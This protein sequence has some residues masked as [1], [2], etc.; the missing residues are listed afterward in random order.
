M[1]KFY[2]FTL[3]LLLAFPAGIQAQEF[4][5]GALHVVLGTYGRV[6]VS[7]PDVSVR[8]V[9]R[10]SFLLAKSRTEVFDYQEDAE[11]IVAPATV[12]PATWGDFEINVGID[13]S[14]S[15][16]PP[17]VSAVVSNYGW[18]NASFTISKFSVTNNGTEAFNAIPGFEM[19]PIN[20]GTYG[21]EVLKYDADNSLFY[22]YKGASYVGFKSLSHPLTSVTLFDW[23]DLFYTD[24][25]FYDYMTTGTFSDSVATG[26]DG[27]VAV[28]GAAPVSFAVGA[29]LNM[30]VAIA[31]GPTKAAM[32]EQMG[33][34]VL[35]YSALVGVK[36]EMT[37]ANT[38]ALQ[39]NYPNPFNP[40]TRISFYLEK[41]A[42]TSLRIY[43]VLGNEVAVLVNGQMEKGY[44][45][46]EFDASKL[47]SGMY[48]YR[49]V[50]GQNVAVKKM[51]L[52]K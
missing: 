19:I 29:T 5:T 36:E 47:S 37:A 22:S 18:T 17:V 32:I 11:G 23:Y 33:D 38:F 34:A 13:N 51:S 28:A 9:D 44:H 39:Q 42:E 24:T 4:A 12:S 10:L 48:V 27:G 1:K 3:A 26:G 35:V 50:S 45:E 52:L 21:N 20:E 41:D 16:K 31:Y 49:L 6:R 15:N 25:L 46:A 2:L 14:Y 7:A 30:Y 40:S 43:D 8:Q